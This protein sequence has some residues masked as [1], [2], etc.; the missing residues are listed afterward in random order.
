M[1]IHGD[2]ILSEFSLLNEK[3]GLRPFFTGS[4]WLLTSQALY[5]CCLFLAN[6][7]ANQWPEEQD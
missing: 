4:D 2:G 6:H 1:E 3:R 7:F 5:S